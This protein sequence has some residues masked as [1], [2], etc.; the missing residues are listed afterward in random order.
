MFIRHYT[1]VDRRFEETEVELIAGAGSW[2]SALARRAG[3][4]SAKLL[5][6]VGLPL[7]NRG[8]KVESG[9]KL[10]AARRT[11]GVTLQPFT[12]RDS[13]LFS[14]F[15]GQLELARVGPSTTQLGVSATY[16]LPLNP[17]RTSAERALIHRIAEVALK[18]YLDE[19]GHRLDRLAA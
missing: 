6:E 17:A 7:P 10:G 4:H 19:M 18:G 13:G 8:Q 12:W 14:V 1:V 9:L 11:S 2:I 5:A 15:E 3:G 16:M